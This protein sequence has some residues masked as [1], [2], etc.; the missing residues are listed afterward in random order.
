M[1]K[2]SSHRNL[3]R[4]DAPLTPEHGARVLFGRVSELVSALAD[5]AMPRAREFVRLETAL[6]VPS[7]K[8]PESASRL[9]ISLAHT[10]HGHSAMDQ[11]RRHQYGLSRCPLIPHARAIH[12]GARSSTVNACYPSLS[13]AVQAKP[14]NSR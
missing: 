10:N 1:V 14:I 7:L 9:P 11:A 3:S 8:S 4:D 6:E 13:C 2:A 12:N 5:S